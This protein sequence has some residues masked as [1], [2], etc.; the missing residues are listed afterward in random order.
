MVAH[1]G[2]LRDRG[3]HRPWPRRPPPPGLS[4]RGLAT[5]ALAALVVVLLTIHRTAGPGDL[6]RAAAEYTVVAL[7]AG[8]RRHRGGPG[9]PA[10]DRPHRAQQ[11]SPRQRPGRGRRRPAAALRAV[12]T[13]LR[14]GAAVVRAATGAARWLID[15]WRAKPTT[16]PLPRA[17]RWPPRPLPRP[18]LLLDLE[19][20]RL[21]SSP[22]ANLR[23]VPG[24]ALLL[25]LAVAG[26]AFTLSFFAC[27]DAAADLALA[28]GQGHAWLFPIGVDM[29]L[30]FEVLLLGASMVRITGRPGHPVPAGHSVPAHA[31]AAAGTL[32]FNAT[33]VPTPVRPRPGRTGGQHPGHPRAGVSAEDAGRR[34]GS[35][36]H[37]PRSRP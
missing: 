34:L 33:H 6:A 35:R 9:R 12:T 26:A 31:I 18:R 2:R 3:R 19:V 15:L 21:M 4:T 7:L 17:R 36:R 22:P 14:A 13:V 28:W 1:P 20:P 32:Y 29:A 37:P 25:G 10:A 11:A 8:L 5:V 27:A 30:F 23:T 16:R 24:T